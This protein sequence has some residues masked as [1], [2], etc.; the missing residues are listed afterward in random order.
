MKG[1]GSNPNSKEALRQATAKRK[2]DAEKLNLTLSP[3]TKD[4]LTEAAAVL[5]ISRSELV[6]R[7]GRK[8]KEWLVEAGRVEG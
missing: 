5:N 7:L 1:K 3:A 4:A 8:G 2:K 6:E